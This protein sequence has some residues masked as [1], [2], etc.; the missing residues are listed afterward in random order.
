MKKYKWFI[1]TTFLGLILFL[2]LAQ[3]SVGGAL[4]GFAGFLVPGQEF[5]F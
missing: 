1:I 4:V 3:I 2:F 5:E